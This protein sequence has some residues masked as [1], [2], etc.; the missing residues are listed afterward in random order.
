ML[1]EKGEEPWTSRAEGNRHRR[2]VLGEEDRTDADRGVCAGRGRQGA[3]GRVLE[4]GKSLISVG[5]RV[6]PGAELERPRAGWAQRKGAKSKE[7]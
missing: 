2:W 1:G 4:A 3:P 5:N 6:A 7:Y